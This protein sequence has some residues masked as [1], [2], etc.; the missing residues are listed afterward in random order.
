VLG[1]GLDVPEPGV[2][3]VVGL[4]LVSGRPLMPEPGVVGVVGFGGVPG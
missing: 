4:G 3:G 1:L 2:V